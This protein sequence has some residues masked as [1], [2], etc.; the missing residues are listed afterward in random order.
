MQLDIFAHSREVMLRNDV[1]VAIERR[2]AAA[3]R[4]A[5]LLLQGENENAETLRVQ[6]TL[7]DALDS[8]TD[9]P[10][11]NH[12]AARDA[13]VALADEIIPAAKRLLGD[14][15]ASVWVVPLWRALAER[16]ASL[17]FRADCCEEHAAPLWLQAGDWAAAVKAIARVES[18]RRI[19]APLAWM[20]EARYRMAGLDATWPL[21]VELAW[22]SPRKFDSVTRAIG[23]A[24]LERLRKRFDANFE[25]DGGLADLAWFPA[26]LLTDTPALG[27]FVGLAQPSRQEAAE[28]AMHLLLDLLELERQGRHHDLV[29]RRRELRGLD[30]TLYASYMATR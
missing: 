23:D 6:A 13:R 21:L 19:P 5:R 10:F 24:I 26:W 17:A 8:A 9:A 1:A 15:A 27:R 22:L 18:W 2:D 3:A 14:A 28:R 20:A 25:R 29:A 7:I 11:A 16:A 4:A 12:S 30:A